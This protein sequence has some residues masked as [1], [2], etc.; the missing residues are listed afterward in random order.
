[1][2][3]DRLK[4]PEQTRNLCDDP[5]YGD[6]MRA[7]AQRVI[8]HNIEVDSPALSWLKVQAGKLGL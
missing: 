4:D 5:Q 7:L 8:Q 6:V 2:L 3:F 1:M